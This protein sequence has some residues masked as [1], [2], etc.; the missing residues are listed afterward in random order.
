MKFEK[1]TREKICDT[2][3]ELFVENGFEKTTMKEIADQLGINLSLV[4]YHFPRKQ[5]ILYEIF[6]EMTLAALE[7]GAEAAQGN[8]ILAFYLSFHFFFPQLMNETYKDMY[9]S[10]VDRTAKDDM[11]TYTRFMPHNDRLVKFLNLGISD[12]ELYFRNMYIFSGCKELVKSYLAGN[13]KI[14]EKGLLNLMFENVGRALG[15]SDYVIQDTILKGES[16]LTA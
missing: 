15:I 1:S 14:D 12:E 5:E 3:F 8:E 11:Q 4:N 6:G 7:K 13:L 2:S 10:L 9:F 16:F